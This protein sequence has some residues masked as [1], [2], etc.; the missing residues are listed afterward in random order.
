VLVVGADARRRANHLRGRLGGFA[1]TDHAALERDPALARRYDHLVV[2]DPPPYEGLA[3]APGPLVHL[4]YGAPEIAYA[5]QAHEH[6]YA[7]RA[8]TAALYKALRDGGDVAHLDPVV[9]ARA[10]TVLGELGLVTGLSVR[11]GAQRTELQLSPAYRAYTLKLDD[12]RRWLTSLATGTGTGAAP[13]PA[14]AAAA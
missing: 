7:L 14:T 12:G 11:P 2:L 3:A 5:L 9:A 8:H 6:H 10:L 13:E 1:L 4:V